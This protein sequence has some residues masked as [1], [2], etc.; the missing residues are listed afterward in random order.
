MICSFEDLI[1]DLDIGRE[2][3]FSFKTKKYYIG[4]G[5]GKY[6]FLGFNNEASKIG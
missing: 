2:I 1:L 3:E 5:T 6:M 4:C